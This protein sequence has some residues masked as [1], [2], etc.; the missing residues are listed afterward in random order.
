M[1]RGKVLLIDDERPMH[2]VFTGM[3][4][5]EQY[6]ARA[7]EDVN[8][9][10]AMIAAQR[11]DVIVCDLMMPIISGLDFLRQRLDDPFLSGI[12]VIITSAYGMEDM[13][14]DARALGA[15]DILHKPFS[16]QELLEMLEAA[17]TSAGE[18]E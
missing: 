10:L 15:F 3:L 8:E 6:E 18:R 9:G 17:L 1:T 4:H 13:I 11:P 16:R 5:L 12:P 7:A 2:S 14:E